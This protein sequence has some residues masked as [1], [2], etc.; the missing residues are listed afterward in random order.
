[1]WRLVVLLGLFTVPS[2]LGAT[3]CKPALAF[4]S[5]TV[6]IQ[7]EPGTRAFS[8]PLRRCPP[9]RLPSEGVGSLQM[10]TGM[11]RTAEYKDGRFAKRIVEAAKRKFTSIFSSRENRHATRKVLL[12]CPCNTLLAYPLSRY[13]ASWSTFD[14]SCCCMLVLGHI[15]FSR[16]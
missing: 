8:L 16:R 10:R 13:R 4:S 12:K 6:G 2:G 7:R 1:M 15:P 14:V 11:T 5:L 3:S 9:L